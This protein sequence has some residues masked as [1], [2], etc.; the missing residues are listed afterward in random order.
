MN[1]TIP[2]KPRL[3]VHHAYHVYKQV[4]HFKLGFQWLLR[5]RFVRR[6]SS[7]GEWFYR[8]AKDFMC[9]HETMK[10]FFSILVLGDYGY[11]YVVGPAM[12][13]WDELNVYSTS[14]LSCLIQQSLRY[15]HGLVPNGCLT[16]DFENFSGCSTNMHHRFPYS[17]SII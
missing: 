4:R 16:V 14:R 17:G 13:L 11:L 9:L 5:L 10:R 8:R 1:L 2:Y 6:E 3:L 12:A 7:S 15:P